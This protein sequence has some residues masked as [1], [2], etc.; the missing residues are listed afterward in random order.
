MDLDQVFSSICRILFKSEI[1]NINEFYNFLNRYNEPPKKLNSIISGQEVYV[2]NY[3]CNNSNFISLDELDQ[4]KIKPIRVYDFND[5]DALLHEIKKRFVYA[6]NK[7]LGNSMDV[8]ES[9]NCTDCFHVYKSKEIMNSEHIIYSHMIRDSKFLIGCSWGALNNFC[10]N[11]TEIAQV[12]RSFESAF[13][14]KCSDIYYSYNC[15]NCYEV[16][17]CSHL[18]SK[19]YCIGNNEFPKE[20]YFKLKEKLI[21]EM[22]EKL[23]KN[24]TLPSLIDFHLG[25]M[26][27]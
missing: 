14:V 5:P 2:S 26:P 10:M 17:F 4:L 16:M 13:L 6:G 1:G 24:K 15:K 18:F 9:E 23:K 8:S 3:Y 25:G 21:G 11:T 27:L 7:I 22:L 12:T 19:K 20:D